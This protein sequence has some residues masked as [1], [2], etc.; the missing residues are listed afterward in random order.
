M[1]EFFYTYD[2]CDEINQIKSKDFSKQ[3]SLAMAFAFIWGYYS[4]YE[5]EA[6]ENSSI[7]KFN[8]IIR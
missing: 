2:D 6:N 8:V 5:E 1:E 3:C 7:D 4:A